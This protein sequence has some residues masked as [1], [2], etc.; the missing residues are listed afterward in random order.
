[1]RF[2]A[3]GFT[4][5]ELLVAISVM[6]ILSVASFAKFAVLRED[7]YLKNASSEIQSFI[8]FAQTNATSNIA[9]TPTLGGTPWTLTF[10]PDKIDLSCQGSSLKTLTLSNNIRI[11]SINYSGCSTSDACSPTADTFTGSGLVTTAFSPLTG[12]ITFSDP[13]CTPAS[14]LAGSANMVITLKKIGGSDTKPV[15]LSRGGSVEIK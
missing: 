10:S 12:Q 2:S 1:M 5:V 3:H 7:Q 6:A 4:L 9:C 11:C 14:G 8:R 13:R 15:T